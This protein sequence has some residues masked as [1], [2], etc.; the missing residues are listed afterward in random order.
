MYKTEPQF[1]ARRLEQMKERYAQAWMNPPELSDKQVALMLALADMLTGPTSG[2]N[3]AY[4]AA[5]MI[6]HEPDKDAPEL[7][8]AMRAALKRE[9]ALRKACGY[10]IP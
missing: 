4:L 5:H 8:R 6:G 3:A 9:K 1:M 2:G 7:A 10:S